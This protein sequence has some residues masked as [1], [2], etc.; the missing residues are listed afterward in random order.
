MVTILLLAGKKQGHN[1]ARE[2]CWLCNNQ[3]L[4]LHWLKAWLGVLVV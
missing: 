4:A 3:E 1:Y 2:E